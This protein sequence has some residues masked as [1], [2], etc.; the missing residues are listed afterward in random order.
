MSSLELFRKVPQLRVLA[1]GGD[2]TVGW[3]LSVLDQIGIM[4][5]PAVGVLPLGTGNDLARALGWGGVSRKPFSFNLK[6][7]TLFIIS[8]ILNKSARIFL[9]IFPRANHFSLELLYVDVFSC[10]L[11]PLLPHSV[12]RMW[13]PRWLYKRNVNWIWFIW[14]G[15]PIGYFNVTDTAG[16]WCACLWF[17]VIFSAAYANAINTNVELVFFLDITAGRIYIE[18]KPFVYVGVL[19]IYLCD[20]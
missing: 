15:N 14:T 16:Y 5:A 11:Y 17:F 12:C 10:L 3:V 13:T 19:N 4:P 18:L 6:S 8:L 20:G 2:G 1:C 9:A 7:Y